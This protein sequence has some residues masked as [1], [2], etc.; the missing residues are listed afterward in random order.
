ML[1]SARVYDVGYEQR[2][3]SVTG[4]APSDP[5]RAGGQI[6]WI[7][8]VIGPDD[9]VKLSEARW[10]GDLDVVLLPPNVQNNG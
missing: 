9:A 4:A 3:A 1:Q 7:T 8:L 6:S 10:N 2:M 5:A